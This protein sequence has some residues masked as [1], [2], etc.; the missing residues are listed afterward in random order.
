MPPVK[1]IADNCKF[2]CA[3]HDLI[4]L[5][6]NLL[7]YLNGVTTSLMS[8]FVKST[9]HTLTKALSAGPDQSRAGRRA[10]VHPSPCGPGAA[11]AGSGLPGG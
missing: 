11:C 8:E 9:P 4:K 1:L 7:L 3:E 6:N 2:C 10:A 5:I